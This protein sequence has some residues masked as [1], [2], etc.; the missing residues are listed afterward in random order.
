MTVVH[1]FKNNGEVGAP[2]TEAREPELSSRSL[3]L[4]CF[5]NSSE[6]VLL[7]IPTS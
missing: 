3:L 4:I 2:R 6:C 1:P 7:I 5:I